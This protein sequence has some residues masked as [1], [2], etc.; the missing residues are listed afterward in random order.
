LEGD[1]SFSPVILYLSS[2]FIKLYL[3]VGEDQRHN[4]E[5]GVDSMFQRWSFA[6]LLRLRDNS[7]RVCIWAWI[8]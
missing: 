1:V 7:K 8:Q 2:L 5:V 3:P 4:V 6:A